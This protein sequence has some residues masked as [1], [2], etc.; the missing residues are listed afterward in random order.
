M[1]IT[2]WAAVM[3]IA[4]AGWLIFNDN[5]SRSMEKAAITVLVALLLLLLGCGFLITS[6]I[7][8]FID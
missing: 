7:L 4:L 8:W 2:L 6:G 3:T 5:P 1:K